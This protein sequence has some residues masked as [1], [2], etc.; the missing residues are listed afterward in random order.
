MMSIKKTV[1]AFVSL[2]AAWVALAGMPAT[3]P[4]HVSSENPRYFADPS[5]GIVYLTGSH[6]WSTC[7]IWARQ[8]RL[9]LSI[10]PPTSNF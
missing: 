3:G 1:F 6:T 9:P 8:T 7:K 2:F 5:G 4:L 10:T